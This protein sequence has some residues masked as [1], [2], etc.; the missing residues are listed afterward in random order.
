VFENRVQRRIF[1]AKREEVVW[2]VGEDYIMR[3]FVKYTL[4]QI[5]LQSSNQGG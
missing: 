2:V 4:R 1:G 3:S 5:L